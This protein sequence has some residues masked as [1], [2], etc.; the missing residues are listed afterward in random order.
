MAQS[1]KPPTLNFG[2]GHDLT[3]CEIKPH[4]RLCADSVSL[5]GISLSPFLSIS[6]SLCLSPK[7]ALDLSLSK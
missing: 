1:V 7:L 5:L 2:S 6:L 4:I 3:V